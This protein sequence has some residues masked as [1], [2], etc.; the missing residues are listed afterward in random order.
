MSTPAP[1]AAPTPEPASAPPAPAAPA[2]P[3]PAPTAPP[4]P[5][6]GGAPTAEQLA[7]LPEW[8]RNRLSVQESE[9]TRARGEAAARRVELR[10][11]A[12][13]LA[14]AP[15]AQAALQAAAERLAAAERQLTRERLGRQHGLPDALVARIAGD[16]D[17]AMETDAKALAALLP[18]PGPRMPVPDPLQGGGAPAPLTPGEEFAGFLSRALRGE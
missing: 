16:T 17:E 5:T 12:A 18:Q 15:D 4:A 10:E 1:P 2:A 14:A 3:V 8:A 7:E 13:Q 11:T 9:L 6:N